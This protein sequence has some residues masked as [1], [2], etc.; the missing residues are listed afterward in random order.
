MQSKPCCLYCTEHQEEVHCRFSF[1]RLAMALMDCPCAH[2]RRSTLLQFKIA[3]FVWKPNGLLDA[4]RATHPVSAARHFLHQQNSTSWSLRCGV[5][6]WQLALQKIIPLQALGFT[7][8]LWT[9]P[10]T[11]IATSNML[12]AMRSCCRWVQWR[13]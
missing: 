3:A 10:R 8:L 2:L 12:Q 7:T 4:M 6:L 5:A 9:M 11:H 13:F 1:V